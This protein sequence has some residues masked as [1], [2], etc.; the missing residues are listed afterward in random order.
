V[1]V[2]AAVSAAA[3]AP[4]GP[5]DVSVLGAK[6]HAALLDLYAL[7]TRLH[8]AQAR[9]ATLQSQAAQL[10]KQQARLAQ[11]LSATRGTLQVSQQRLAKNLRTL[12]EQGEV[13][14]LAVV[15]GAQSLDDAMTKLDDL[16]RVADQ[17]R[18][19]VVVT[20]AAQ[21]R[22]TRLR[23]S[24]A[25]RRARLNVSI[26]SARRTADDLAAAHRERVAFIGSLQLKA[27]RLAALQA[28]AQRVEAKSQQLQAAA[29]V[30]PPNPATSDVSSTTPATVADAP[31]AAPASGVRTITV[32]ST[33]YSLPGRTATGIPV[34]WGVV[35]VDPSL[36][37]L[38]TRLTIPGYG[39]GVAADT[40]GAVRGASIDLWFPTHAQALA[41]GRRTVTIT[42]H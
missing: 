41:W 15:L 28:A 7:D 27:R 10:R 26:T 40:G 34:G 31:T 3:A 16:T 8:T 21:N 33:G 2:L 1:V 11:Q 35:A 20:S 38:G 12:Y 13:D 32:S 42:L 29:S 23:T 5:R 18:E 6:T 36:I 14:P 39:E 19:F 22:L 9:L 4:P 17:S 30:L 24:L 37:P 25:D